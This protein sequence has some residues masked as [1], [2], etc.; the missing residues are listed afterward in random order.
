MA[1]FRVQKGHIFGHFPSQPPLQFSP[2]NSLQRWYLLPYVHG[3]TAPPKQIKYLMVKMCYRP[4][5]INTLQL[6]TATAPP[7]LELPD[8]CNGCRR[9]WGWG[10]W[11]RRSWGW[12]VRECR[13]GE[14]GDSWPLIEKLPDHS[15]LTLSK[16]LLSA[17]TPQPP[18]LKMNVYN[19]RPATAL[20]KKQQLGGSDI[21]I[22]STSIT[23]NVL[24]QNWK[25]F[26]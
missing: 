15:L 14:C 8:G 5:K 16:T 25:R 2:Q 26:G 3:S 11:G 20:T 1:G 4:L 17:T 24:E 13:E 10:C 12:G 9:G 19:P 6:C 22:V 7:S 23:Y 21:L 18:P